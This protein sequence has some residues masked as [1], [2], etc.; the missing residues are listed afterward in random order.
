M[1]SVI[2]PHKGR[3]GLL[4]RHLYE[5]QKQTFDDFEVIIVL[6]EPAPEEGFWYP[7]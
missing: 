3:D 6:D 2:I 4:I 5:L 1:I 7:R